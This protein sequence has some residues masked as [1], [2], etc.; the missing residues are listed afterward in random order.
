MTGGNVLWE[1]L[2]PRLKVALDSLVSIGFGVIQ[3]IV[4][5][6]IARFVHRLFRDKLMQ[7][8]DSPSLTE[9]GR[10]AITIV[11]SIVVGVVSGTVL[12][13]LWGVTWGGIVTAVSLG[14]LGILLGIQDVLKSLIGGVFLVME[15]PYSIGDRVQFRDVTGRII[16]IE[17]RTTILRSDSGHRIVAPN[18]I[19]FT[20][21]ITNYSVERQIRTTVIIRNI[22][23][24]PVGLRP[25][26][27]ESLKGVSGID[28][29]PD[30]RFLVHGREVT[31]VASDAGVDSSRSTRKGR[32]VEVRVSWVGSGEP[33][34]QTAV[35]DRLRPFFPN[36]TMR[37]RKH[38]RAISD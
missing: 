32:N 26:M 2:Q 6:L 33:E 31:S 38:G 30:I 21:T 1:E 36:A 25:D 37:V 19:V 11:S 29:G 27:L 24:D 35:V 13:A 18:S 16:A 23:G 4:V 22:S 9:S 5:I 10:S 17:L 3:A 20:D 8:V 12:L 28:E 14:T 15:R 7:R 34:V